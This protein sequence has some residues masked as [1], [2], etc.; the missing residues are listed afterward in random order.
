MLNQKTGSMAKKQILVLWS[1]LFGVFL[2]SSFYSLQ[3]CEE[4]SDS[5]IRFGEIVFVDDSTDIHWTIPELAWPKALK[6]AQPMLLVLESSSDSGPVATLEEQLLQRSTARLME[7]VV[8][9]RVVLA[10]GDGG[11]WNWSV[12]DPLGDSEESAERWSRDRVR[13]FLEKMFGKPDGKSKIAI[14]DLLGR[15][16]AQLE[17]D[18]ISGSALRKGL[19]MAAKECSILARKMAQ[20][21]RI[22]DKATLLLQRGETANCCRQLEQAQKL[23]VPLEAP[24]EK[25][26]IEV[27]GLLEKKWREAMAK[28]K[29]LERKNRLGEAASAYEKI[30]KDFPHDPWEKEIR[31]EIGRVW[32]RIQGPGGGL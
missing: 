3:A 21:S 31:Q 9:V 2:S 22:V 26:R 6:L 24:P 20:E 28:A 11:G 18:K 8:A 15:K 23:K 27:L 5:R 30:L 7:K 17:G 10:E 25:R 13:P 14:L 29:E 1:I 32:R 16:R 12:E 19:K 4:C